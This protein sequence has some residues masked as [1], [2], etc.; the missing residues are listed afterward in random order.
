M[1]NKVSSTEPLLPAMWDRTRKSK[2]LKSRQF[3]KR[4]IVSVKRRSYFMVFRRDMTA[5][6]DFLCDKA[7][8]LG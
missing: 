3:N 2:Y 5:D 1:E 6:A 4:D 7:V 8:E